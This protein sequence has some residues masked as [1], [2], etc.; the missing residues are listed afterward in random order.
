M[1][2]RWPQI[3][4]ALL[5]VVIVSHGIVAL[6]IGPPV[7][8]KSL[9]SERGRAEVDAWMRIAGPLGFSREGFV[10]AVKLWSERLVA[11]DRLLTSPIKPV[12]RLTR[13]GQSWAL[14][15][16]PD[17]DPQ[18][19]EIR[20]VTAS[21]DTRLLYR[22]LDPDHTFLR[23]QLDF[24]RVRG[25]YDLTGTSKPARYKNFAAWA[26]AAALAAYPDLEA[27]EIAQ[28]RTYTTLPGAPRDPRIDERHHVRID[29]SSP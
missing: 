2:S 26:G 7:T 16:T 5:T 4:T 28:K 21:G 20:G 25:V 19:L 13:T 23:P 1:A 22:R 29:R 9:N 18:C 17:D 10:D 24:R 12:M 27:V 11:T 6:P 8:D 3:R 15:A 14:F